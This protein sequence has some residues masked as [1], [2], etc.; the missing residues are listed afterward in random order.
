MVSSECKRY[1][2]RPVLASHCNA[3]SPGP[4]YKRADVVIHG[5]SRSIKMSIPVPKPG[6]NEVLIKNV[7]VASNP[8]DWKVPL[9][10][11]E[12]PWPMVEGN[13]VAGTIAAVGEGNGGVTE[14]KVGDRV[15]SFSRMAIDSKYGAYAEYTV[16]P[17]NTT[18]PLLEGSSFEEAATFPLAYMTAVLG[19]F[20]ALKLPTPLEPAT[21]ERWVVI[22]GASS[23]VGHFAVQLAKLAHLKAIA[24]AGASKELAS[25]ADVTIDYRGKSSKELASAV[26]AAAPEKINSLFDTISEAGTIRT[27]VDIVR[28]NGGRI[29]I[30]LPPPED[31]EIPSNVTITRTMVGSSFGK[32]GPFSDYS[33]G[34]SGD[35]SEIAAR[36]YRLLSGW[37]SEGKVK[38]NPVKIIAGG[39]AGVDEGLKLLQANKVS[40]NKLV[41]RIAETPDV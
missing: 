15:A 10:M 41:Y 21:S 1:V 38:P 13:D 34:S 22:N 27:A 3:T 24:V 16:S 17:A 7:A 33:E 32:G 23:S 36:Y 12:L 19:L 18:F 29:T 2:N 37:F 5:S 11:A 30:L 35:N 40:G 8:K 4:R 31:I 14:Y 9:W 39:L 20:V 28:E 25:Q 26:L 6:P